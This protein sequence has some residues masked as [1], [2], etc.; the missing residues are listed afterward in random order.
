ESLPNFT[1]LK[2]GIAYEE[3]ENEDYTASNG[4]TL[5]EAT[6]IFKNYLR[7][8]S[9]IYAVR[10]VEI[11]INQGEF[12]IVMGP[13]GSGKT[14]L[15][16]ILAGLETVNRG[17]VFFNGENLLSMKDRKKSNM[18][19]NN[20][21]FIFQNYAL[22]PHLTA[23][24]NV[25]VPLDLTGLSK[26]LQND[27]QSLLDSVGIGP[28]ADHKPALLSGGQ[29]QR[30]G[31]A[32]A[33]IAKPQVI[34]ADEPTGDLDRKTSIAIMELLKKYHQETGVT[35]VLVTHDEEIATYGTR[36]IKVKDGQI[37]TN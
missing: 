26:E 2:E 30:L 5:I 37:L 28:Y 24:E 20:F 32:R 34:F 22:I 21:S 4:N 17:A 6:K 27:I 36:L 12:A 3:V 23:H 16:N 18:R 29:M 19:K 10:G 7:G 14:T 35:I 33:L 31:I 25:K 15:L 13:S 1:S 11:E 8:G 9:T